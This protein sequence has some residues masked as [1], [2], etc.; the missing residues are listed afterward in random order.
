ML[1]HEANTKKICTKY[2]FINAKK[3]IDKDRKHCIVNNKYFK[4]ALIIIS[5]P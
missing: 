3:Y 4:I 5:V 2:M 1:V